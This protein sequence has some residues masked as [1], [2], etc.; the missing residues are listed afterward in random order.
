MNLKQINQL[1]FE[2]VLRK[3]GIEPTITRGKSLFYISPFRPN[4]KTASFHVTKSNRY[5][6][7]FDH[8]E[9]TG[10][11]IV[12][13]FIKYLQTNPKGVLD[14][15]NRNFFSFQ[16]QQSL[17]ETIKIDKD[18]EI[19]ELKEIQSVPLIQYLESRKLPLEL[20]KRYC[21]EIH[22]KMNNRNYFAIAFPTENGFE[23]RNKYVKMCLNGK[24]FSWI[25]NHKNSVKL[26]ESWSD[27][28]SY[29]TLFT[30]Q[31]FESDFLVLNSISLL[32]NRVDS[33]EKYQKIDVYLDA[34]STGQSATKFL[35][36]YFG[37]RVKNISNLF[38][39]FK[40]VNDFL[41]HSKNTKIKT[42]L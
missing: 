34:D 42:R 41:M 36:E 26:F 11:K 15:F 3:L 18:Y 32:R 2:E 14:Y 5:D 8:G 16:Q 6:L 40:D 19:L 1:S 37:C 39:P 23:I 31:E 24:G 13:F 38:E 17:S 9:G 20:T 30:K 22:Y 33:L 35:S 12:D 29:L 21:K 28:L 25:L 10:G 7:F 27:F 4:E